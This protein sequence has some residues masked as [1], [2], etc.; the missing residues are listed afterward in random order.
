[1]FKNQAAV[2]QFLYYYRLGFPPKGEIF[3]EFYPGKLKL[4]KSLFELLYYAKDYDTFYKTA[5]WAR[6]NINEGLYL[7]ALSV[8]VIHRPDTYGIILPP[9]YELNPY[10][11][12]NGDVIQKAQWYRE[13]NPNSNEGT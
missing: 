13:E 9:I 11:F 3:S 1:M 2:K 4:A 6:V 7:Y 8:A 12:Y 10:Y 5:A